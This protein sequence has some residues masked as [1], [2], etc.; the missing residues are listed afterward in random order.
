MFGRLATTTALREGGNIFN[1]SDY[2]TEKNALIDGALRR[3]IDEIDDA[4]PTL[5]EAVRY[6]VFAGGKRIRPILAVSAAEAVGGNVDDAVTA[7]AAIECIHTYSLIHDDLPAMDDDDFRRGVPTSHRVFGEATAILAGDCLLTN[8]F[9][10]LSDASRF[11]IN[12]S[13]LLRV[14]HEI[15]EASGDRGMVGGQQA[16]L[17]SEGKEID[18]PSL[19][20]IHIRKT[21]ALIVASV[22]AGAILGGGTEPQ[23][24]LL[25]DYAKHLG[26]AFQIT[27]DILDVTGTRQQMGKETGKDHVRGKA[28]YPALLGLA[29]SKERAQELIDRALAALSDFGDGARPLR[30]IAQFVIERQA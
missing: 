14:I 15:A 21:G 7:G 28:T 20:F 18:L 19:E 16:D 25:T 22:R 17:E 1:L 6:S 9:T 11:S 27:D 2:L 13:C 30:A 4:S 12:G 8:A 10:L 26:L 23:V 5:K 24:K 29:Q 3:F